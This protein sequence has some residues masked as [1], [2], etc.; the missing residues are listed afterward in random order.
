MNSPTPKSVI[1]SVILEKLNQTL[2]TQ[3]AIYEQSHKASL[4]A[5]GKMQSRY[6]TT[7]EEMASLANSAMQSMGRTRRM[8]SFFSEI[9][10]ENGLSQDVI[11]IGTVVIVREQDRKETYFISKEAGGVTVEIDKEKFSV[12]SAESPIGKIL[13]G[14]RPG[15]EIQIAAPGGKRN[16][17]IE[18]I[19]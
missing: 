1:I 15:T 10:T 7:K 3:N 14:Q 2:E 8:I 4:E 6:D 13:I 11:G 18:A 19:Y 12:V 9:N 5:D 17:T 16:L